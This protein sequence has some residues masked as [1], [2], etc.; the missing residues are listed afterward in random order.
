LVDDKK[1]QQQP[2][3]TNAS[4]DIPL[5]TVVGKPIYVKHAIIKTK[6]TKINSKHLPKKEDVAELDVDQDINLKP[7]AIEGGN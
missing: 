3:Y 1:L 5:T 2:Q 4:N 6:H 7:L